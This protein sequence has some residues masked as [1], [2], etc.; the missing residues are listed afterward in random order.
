MKIIL[1]ASEAMPFIKTGGL[2][3]VTG[4]L[5]REYRKLGIEAWLMLPLYRGIK[6]NFA[7]TDTGLSINVPLGD[8]QL[9]CKL[10]SYDERVYFIENDVFFDRTEPYGTAHGDYPDNAAR[11][12]FL[13]KAILEAC[14]TV[15][16]QPDVLH[17]NDWQ[18]GLVPL[19]LK[20]IY[21]N[22]FFNRTAT[23]MTIHNLGYQGVF[24]ISEFY[25]TD[26]G[27][28]WFKPEGVEFYG[29][30]NFLK[31]G[32][33]AA[34]IITT[35]SNTYA[36]EILTIEHGYGLEGVLK[37]RLPDLYGVINGIAYE[38]W[39]PFTDTFIA[40]GYS[41]SDMTGKALC[42]KKLMEDCSLLSG[43]DAPPL[44]AVVGRLST[45]KGLDILINSVEEMLLMGA[46]LVVLGKGDQPFQLALEALAE[47]YKGNVFIEIGYNEAFAH[48]IY[49]GSDIF[50]M[51]SR[52]EPCGLGQLI[53]MRYG[54]IPVA[55]KTGGLA[56]TVIDYVPLSG[57]GTG[58]LFD[59]YSASA[60][61][62]CLRSALCVYADKKRWS[63]LVANA[64]KMD[65]SWKNSAG[66]YI[67]LYGKAMQKKAH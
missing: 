67:E 45:Q 28:E 33:I 37:N 11:F 60:L 18:T 54:T 48:R 10:W 66:R 21:N 16:L 30:V 43:K 12:I 26:L 32:L 61:K 38:E 63:R 15:G 40:K 52:Y 4:A 31:A 22:V 17:C 1:A 9:Y 3:D 7:L 51:P 8:R 57:N 65:F 20:T 53:A 13:S 41:S 24:D 29:K 27:W 42:K 49:A 46:R 56:D 39:S 62:E 44:I 55:R 36:S 59:D 50:L 34:D 2:A 23:I 64:M 19:Y 6:E 14:M 5:Y 25:L 47:K 35:V 58:F